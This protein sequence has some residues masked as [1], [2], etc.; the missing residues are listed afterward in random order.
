MAFMI[1]EECNNCGAC[2]DECPNHAV[3]EGDPVYVID[4]DNCT[5]CVGF[6]DEPQCKSICP[7]DCLVADPAHFESREELLAKKQRL[8]SNAQ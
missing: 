8:Y 7:C 6:F 3:F 1:T 5:E 4:A 2:V